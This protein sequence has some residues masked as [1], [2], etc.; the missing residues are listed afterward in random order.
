M[1]SRVHQ[2][3]RLSRPDLM[4]RLIGLVGGHS[5]VTLDAMVT[6]SNEKLIDMI[7]T[8]EESIRAEVRPLDPCPQCHSADLE[9]KGSKHVCPQCGYIQPCCNP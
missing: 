4:G 2:L 9:P 3:G 8:E 1:S 6:W 7:I 5:M